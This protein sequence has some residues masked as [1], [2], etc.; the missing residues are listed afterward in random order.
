MACERYQDALSDVAAGASAPAEL[1][2]HLASCAACRGELDALGQA[3]A[4]T[5]AVLA[6]LHDEQPSPDLPARIRKAVAASEE[7]P[8]RKLALPWGSALAA[9]AVLAIGLAVVVRTERGGELVTVAPSASPGEP[10]GAPHSANGAPAMTPTA[11]ATR[12]AGATLPAGHTE[13]LP[14]RPAAAVRRSEPAGAE[15]LV[16]AGEADAL[17]RLVALVHQQRIAAPPVL[18]SSNVPATD[19][20]EPP[21]IEIRPLEIVPLDPAEPSGT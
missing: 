1:E 17:L 4:M 8:S 14:V 2:A 7:A 12:A 11:A 16:L 5:D 10:A 3:L 19:L 18:A 20:L 9:A 15:V 6:R 21:A 13:P